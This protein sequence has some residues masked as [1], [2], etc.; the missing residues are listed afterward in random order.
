MKLI[1]LTAFTFFTSIAIAQF[2]QSPKKMSL[3]RENTSHFIRHLYKP[4]KRIKTTIVGDGTVSGNFNLKSKINLFFLLQNPV[5]ELLKKDPILNE[6]GF[7]F[8]ANP[9]LEIPETMGDT[10]YMKVGVKLNL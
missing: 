9:Y 8:K 6:S 2:E 10:G 5:I 4:V 7:H 1:F 3:L